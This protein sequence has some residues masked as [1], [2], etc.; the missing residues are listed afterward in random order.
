MFYNDILSVTLLIRNKLKLHPTP[1]LVFI[2]L[3]FLPSSSSFFFVLI[4]VEM[5]M[6]GIGPAPLLCRIQ[7]PAPPLMH[8]LHQYLGALVR[9]LLHLLTVHS[10]TLP[11]D[12]RHSLKTKKNDMFLSRNQ[13]RMET[14][15][16]HCLFIIFSEWIWIFTLTSILGGTKAE[17]RCIPS[18]QLPLIS[19]AFPRELS[20]LDLTNFG[21]ATA[22]EFLRFTEGSV[23]PRNE[24]HYDAELTASEESSS[25]VQPR[26]GGNISSS[27]HKGAPSSNQKLS[28][29]EVSSSVSS[30]FLSNVTENNTD[31]GGNKIGDV[32]ENEDRNVTSWRRSARSTETWSG[33]RPE[34]GE[35]SSV[36]DQEE[37]HLTSST[38]ALT[39]DTAHNQ[40]MVHWSGQ[41]SSV[42]S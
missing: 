25:K 2:I 21:E 29:S 42:S 23:T 37:F 33:F 18:C 27:L 41:N 19:A 17:V 35:D 1:M 9:A 30:P 38:F 26:F 10:T 4:Q 28:Q 34:G 31:D 24:R 16:G 15:L 13:R 7:P 6:R 8:R 32:T 22:E 20:A 39:E 3:L 14:R 5:M 11:G 36:S 12:D 40:A